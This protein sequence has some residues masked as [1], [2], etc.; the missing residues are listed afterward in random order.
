MISLLLSSVAFGGSSPEISFSYAPFRGLQVMVGDTAVIEASGF[1]YYEAGWKKGYFSSAWKPITIF[2]NGD[3]STTVIANSDDGL[4]ANR[5]VFTPTPTGF[6]AWAE[7]RWRGEKPAMLEYNIGR[8][9]APYVAQGSLMVDQRSVSNITQGP[10]AGSDMLGR[11][12]ASGR[13]IVFNAPSAKITIRSEQALNILDGRN[14]LAEWAD[15]KE[16]FWIGLTDQAIQPQGSIRFDYSVDIEPL[17]LPDKGVETIQMASNILDGANRPEV[18]PLPLLPKPKQI[19]KSGGFV[20]IQGG[21]VFTAPESLNGDIAWLDRFLVGSW[22]WNKEGTPYS[23]SV[24]VMPTAA[25]VNGYQLNVRPDGATIVGQSVEGARYGLRTL[26]QLVSVR[27]GDLG[28]PTVSVSDWPSV[29][30]R[31]VHLFVGPKA[32][33][34]QSALSDRLLAPMKLNKV[35]LQC[36]RTQWDST[37]GI[38]TG[39]TMSKPDL[40]KLAKFYQLEGF[41]VIPLIQSM[42]HM[43]W[44]FANK[45]NLE[46]AVNPDVPYTLDPRKADSRSKISG[47]WREVK[48]LMNPKIAHFGLDEIDNRGMDDE[49]LTNRIWDKGLPMLQSIAKE[50]Q[51]TPMV[52]SDMMLAKGEAA[53]A[54]HAPDKTVSSQRRKMLARGTYVADWH[55]LND[56]NPE[57]FDQSLKMWNSIGMKPI[58]TTWFRPKNIR[59]FTQSAIKNNAGVLQSTWAGYESNEANF[60]REFEQFAAIVMMA[61]YSWSGRTEMPDKLGYDPGAVLQ[62][63]YFG[64]QQPVTPR[65]GRTLGDATDTIQIG[66]YR[67]RP[68]AVRQ[69]FGVTQSLSFHSA[70]QLT[71][72]VVGKAKDVVLAMDCLATVN[73]VALA[74]QVQLNF[75]DGSSEQTEIRY[76]MHVRSVTDNRSTIATPRKGTISALRIPAGNK[77]LKSIELVASHSAAGLRLHGVTIL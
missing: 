68:F 32:L 52:W 67:F 74:G 18:A 76:G 23:I 40:G 44:F 16:L 35:V 26:A 70:H 24:S 20:P 30:W 1:Q 6:K 17:A 33:A 42:G 2:K 21:L 11:I 45:K 13:D 69:L 15:G 51:L 57:K 10:A 65:D 22:D 28:I 71:L 27:G 73:E 58:A 14:Y 12:V 47:I 64:G 25:K 63:L 3:G 55:Y 48:E 43:E 9:W 54:F 75:A 29:Q 72:P 59:G 49:N 56:P 38:E 31:G 61:D 62:R 5:Q 34:F 36:E 53:D 46:L 50:H 60:V 19:Q 77:E 37:P 39:I 66:T 8:L 7:F 4:V 41:E